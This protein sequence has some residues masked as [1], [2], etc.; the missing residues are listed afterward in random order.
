MPA[1]RLLYLGALACLL[2]ALP[3]T[4]RLAPRALDALAA[5][6]APDPFLE[7][8]GALDRDYSRAAGAAPDEAARGELRRL[9]NERAREV[10]RRHGRRW[11][12]VAAFPAPE[13]PASER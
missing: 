5:V 1:C 7:E 6:P 12:G 8:M 9:R 13:T 4:C 2:V 11:P 3:L 10:Y